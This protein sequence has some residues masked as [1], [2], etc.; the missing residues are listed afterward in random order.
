MNLTINCSHQTLASISQT[1]LPRL[2]STQKKIV[3]CALAIFSLF[4]AAY[5][6]FRYVKP[7][8]A[9]KKEIVSNK[10]VDNQSKELEQKDDREV[11]KEEPSENLIENKVNG[12]GNIIL[13][14]GRVAIGTFKNGKLEGKGTL[15]LEQ[16]GKKA[17]WKGTFVNNELQGKGKFTDFDGTVEDGE[18]DHHSLMR[19][20]IVRANGD[21][22][23]GFFKNHLLEG[24][25]GK[26]TFTDKTEWEGEFQGD[27]L[28]GTGIIRHSSG[29]VF[30]GKFEEGKLVEGKIIDSD[31]TTYTGQFKDGKL[32]GEGKIVFS[33]QWSKEGKFDK[34]L[35]NGTGKITYEKSTLKS[36]QDCTIVSET[37]E[38]KD[39]KLI[40]GTIVQYNGEVSEGNFDGNDWLNGQGKM[41]LIDGTV[42]EGDF[43]KDVLNGKGKKI[44]SQGIIWEG[45]FK[46]GNLSAERKITFKDGKVAEGN[47]KDISLT[48]K[49]KISYPN[50]IVYEGVFQLEKLEG[51]GS[52]TQADGT[53]WTGNFKNGVKEGLG[54][55]TF[56][57]GSELDEEKEQKE[58]ELKEKEKEKEL[59]DKEK[60]LKEKELKDEKAEKT[61]NKKGLAG[62]FMEKVKDVKEKVVKKS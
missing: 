39:D 13:L 28:H 54:K 22:A 52:M 50:G 4:A 61:D 20:Y 44:D 19:G 6:I 15:Y 8:M 45:T 10:E 40:K 11:G 2:D 55:I 62:T 35:L 60:E 51:K 56:I 14:D 41:T 7:F 1:I 49:G 53:T 18:F 27:K 16:N 30:E 46:A 47:F 34:G 38:F 9:T 59:K 36:P 32:D 43:E 42:L 5:T 58:K 26:I 57:D 25:Q 12:Q 3:V 23:E 31:G 24:K 37:G 21:R 33:G 17:V 48:G 29:K